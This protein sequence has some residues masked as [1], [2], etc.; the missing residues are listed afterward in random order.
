MANKY[1][2]VVQKIIKLGVTDDVNLILMNK[3]RTNTPS[4]IYV[5]K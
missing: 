3:L 1:L 2:P 5:L 4:S